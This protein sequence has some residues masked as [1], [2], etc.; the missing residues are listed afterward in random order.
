MYADESDLA[1]TRLQRV[2]RDWP[3]YKEELGLLFRPDYQE[4]PDLN[5]EEW[6][7][8]YLHSDVQFLQ[9]HKQH[10]VHPVNENTGEREPLQACRRK[11]KPKACKANFPRTKWIIEKAVVLCQGWIKEMDMALTGRRSMLGS[12]HGPMNHEYLN[13]T[14]PA[15]L[16]VHRFNS[17][18]QLPY[19]FPIMR[20]TCSCDHG[21]CAGELSEDVI[22]QAAQVA[23]DA[24]AGYACDYCNKRQPMAFN[25]VKECCKGHRSLTEELH[26]E[27]PAYE[28]SVLRC[29]RERRGALESRKHKPPRKHQG[30]RRHFGR[31]ISHGSNGDFS[32]P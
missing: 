31:D 14:H 32:W 21:E 2:E 27:R 8:E 24:Q 30:Q 16:A 20:L 18:V 25:E 17:D 23:Q 28:T 15:M 29:V 10:H 1:A 4:D 22:I 3:E 26:G 7:H 19:R 13:A 12:L 5:A 6:L 9:E 11:D